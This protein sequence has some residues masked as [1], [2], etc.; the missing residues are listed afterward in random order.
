[1]TFLVGKFDGILGMAYPS[2]SVGGK[3]ERPGAGPPPVFFSAVAQGLV[4]PTFSFYLK[5]DTTSSDGGE[6]VLGGAD[7]NHYSGDIFWV[8]LTH[9]TYYEFDMASMS[10]GGTNF[11]DSPPCNAIADTGT[12][13]MAGPTDAIK[14]INQAIGATILPTGEATVDCNKI[15][16]L[17]PVDIVLNGKTFTLTAEQYV[18]N[19][20]GECLS[21]FLG[22][23]APPGESLPWILGDVFIGAYYTVFDTVARRVG[24][25]T[26]R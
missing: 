6:M 4:D 14:K 1:M 18:L 17:P 11:C 22:L 7:P 25:A 23:A 20:K 16:S 9:E 21:G 19:V 26:A 8:P 5:R 12:S 10:V 24:F 2:I 3:P 15:S 13:L